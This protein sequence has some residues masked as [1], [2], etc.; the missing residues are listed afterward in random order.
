MSHSQFHCTGRVYLDL[1]GLVFETSICY[2]QDQ[3]G[4]LPWSERSKLLLSLAL[5]AGPGRRPGGAS[6]RAEARAEAAAPTGGRAGV[7]GALQRGGLREYLRFARPRRGSDPGFCRFL[8]GGGGGEVPGAPGLPP[9]PQSPVPGAR[10][11]PAL[12]RPLGR[13]GRLGLAT[14]HFCISFG[15]RAEEVAGRP[16]RVAETRR[17]ERACPA[18]AWRR[19]HWV[20]RNRPPGSRLEA[21]TGGGPPW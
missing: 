10:R 6:P 4:S 12:P 7:C 8:F 17:S 9:P 16:G 20:R 14:F 18:E 5:W 21:G 1:H 15:R 3:P 2:W 13:T 19:A 11:R